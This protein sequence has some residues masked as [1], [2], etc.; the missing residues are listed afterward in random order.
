[1]PMPDTMTY[2]AGE[3]SG[4]DVVEGTLPRE[5]G[6][7]V[8]ASYVNFYVVNDAVVLPVFGDAHDADAVAVL[9][10]LFPEREVVTFPGRE[11][12]LGGGNVH[13]ITQQQPQ[14]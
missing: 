8:P 10:R 1:M 14:G 7:E 3:T 11:V 6:D 12:V 2:T 9:R 4:V 5:A 13:C